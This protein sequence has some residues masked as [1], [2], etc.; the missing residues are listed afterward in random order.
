MLHDNFNSCE[1]PGWAVLPCFIQFGALHRGLPRASLA[2]GDFL[3][4][5]CK[6]HSL[7]TLTVSFNS[8]YNLFQRCDTTPDNLDSGTGHWQTHEKT[9]YLVKN[10]DSR[11]LWDAFGIYEGLV[12]RDVM[13][14][15]F[16][17]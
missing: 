8:D 2:C 9:D 4:L 16:Q 5:V 14:E 17:S 10:F 7:L 12:V 1:V 6:A 15:C 13:H 11:I 3:K